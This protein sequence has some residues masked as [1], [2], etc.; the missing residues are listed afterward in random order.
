MCRVGNSHRCKWSCRGF[1]HA[2]GSC[3]EDGFFNENYLNSTGAQFSM[4]ETKFRKE[5]E[6]CWKND[7]YGFCM[8]HALWIRVFESEI[9]TIISV[10]HSMTLIIDV[11]YSLLIH[12]DEI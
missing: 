9:H 11:R 7:D 12:I 8:S 1:K 4:N 6:R 5:E 10:V 3:T 2:Q